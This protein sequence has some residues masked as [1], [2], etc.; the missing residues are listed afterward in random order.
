MRFIFG[1]YILFDP[2]VCLGDAKVNKKNLRL[3][4]TNLN[5]LYVHNFAKVQWW[6]K[7]YI[8]TYFI[9]HVIAPTEG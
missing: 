1:N 4:N 6:V 5:F 8:I 7:F 2:E 3:A 9:H